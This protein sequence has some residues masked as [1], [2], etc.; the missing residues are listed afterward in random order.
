MV[1][2]SVKTLG[3]EINV[4][5]PETVEEY[6][7]LAKK[8]GACLESAILNTIYRAML[9]VFRS[10]FTEAV[11][12]QTGIAR[13][14]K[15]SGRKVKDDAGKD[16]DEDIL[17]Y[18]ETES[19]YFDRVLVESKQDRTA[20][21][22]LANTVAATLVFDPSA[23]EKKPAGPKK[24]AKK[25]LEAAEA[26]KTAGKLEVVAAML[27]AKLGIVVDATVESL[28][29]AIAEDQRRKSVLAEYGV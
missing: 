17:I 11:E 5:V 26:I 10:D 15:P 25:Y 27:A 21:S 19:E 24:T 14:T 22:S 28:G 13:K 1:S 2:K 18:D 20:F 3:F 29:A 12:K 4:N 6:D 9:N 8:A 16:T 7:V 23:S